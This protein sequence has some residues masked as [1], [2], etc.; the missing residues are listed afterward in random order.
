MASIARQLER[1]ERQRS[2][3]ALVCE[4]MALFSV[5]YFIFTVLGHRLGLIETLDTYWLLAVGGLLLVVSLVAG[6][7][8]FQ[9]LWVDGDEGGLRATRGTLIAILAMIPFL[10]C[11]YLAFA[12]PQLHDISTDLDDPPNFISAYE[13]RDTAA[14][15]IVEAMTE[16]QKE[17]QL[18]AYPKV[19]ARRY[20]LG[21]GRVFRVV[22]ILM[23]DRGWAIVTAET[24]Q[25]QAPIDEEG[26][27]LVARQATDDQGRP[28]RPITPRFRPPE[29]VPAQS[30]TI[31]TVEVSPVG[32]GEAVADGEQEE[33]YIEAVARSLVF[34]FKSDVV[35]RL[36]EEEEG[37]LVDMRSL[38]RF[39]PHDLGSNAARVVSFMEDLDAAL[40]GL[41][42]GT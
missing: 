18:L 38:S 19:S 11:G 9:Q 2:T 10:W 20:P 22:V 35:V 23:R 13:A 1:I 27:G 26:S 30:I 21:S 32:R 39:G 40:Q 31:E 16:L 15:P 4:R 33:R 17:Q 34:G 12:L 6:M 24:E 37:T 3:A 29:A 8:A 42:Q 25:G 7:R 41:S 36:V 5:P 14:N 28:L